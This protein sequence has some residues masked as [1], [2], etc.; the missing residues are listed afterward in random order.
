MPFIPQVKNLHNSREI[1][2]VLNT[3]F[4]CRH[5]ESINHEHNL[6]LMSHILCFI[7]TKIHHTSTDVHKFV[8]SSKY[9]YVFNQ[10]IYVF[11]VMG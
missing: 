11:M 8:N 9:S 5:Y 10:S 1:I 6:Q 7:K 3:I 2:Q 4:L